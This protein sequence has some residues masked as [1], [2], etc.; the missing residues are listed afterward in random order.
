M[1]Y[2]SILAAS[3]IASLPI[4]AVGQVA[5]GPPPPDT[6]VAQP[7]E[8]AP[9]APNAPTVPA[10]PVEKVEKSASYFGMS[11][12]TG[13]GT[14]YS[15]N[16]SVELNDLFAAS[17]KSPTTVAI[18]LRGG[19]GTGDYLLGTQLNVTRT[20]ASSGGASYGLQFVSV[21]LVATWW[22]QEMGISAKVGIGP[23]QVSSFG[24]NTRSNAVQGV[25][26]MAGMGL[27]SGGLGVGIDVTRQ[28][29][30]ASEAGFDS[31]TYVLAMLTLD[32]Y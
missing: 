6:V 23:S 24:G 9:T 12:G 30:R 15:G 21:D 14:L 32:M 13:Q 2:A 18:Q 3:L 31:V 7:A 4:A 19:W 22:S 25:E 28:T 29:Y 10:V 11:L 26:L 1:R 5:E 17:G 27:S 20:S 8:A 16:S